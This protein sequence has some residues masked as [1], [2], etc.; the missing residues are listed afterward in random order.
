MEIGDNYVVVKLHKQPVTGQLQCRHVNR[1][2]N[3]TRLD[4][5]L[6]Q[7]ALLGRR[8]RVSRL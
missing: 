7:F 8:L 3:N 2:Y 6:R 1:K 4:L 5:L